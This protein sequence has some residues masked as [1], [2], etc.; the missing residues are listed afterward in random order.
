MKNHSGNLIYNS[1][2]EFGSL[3]VIDIQQR[4]RSLHF[5][6]GTSQSAMFLYNPI[7]LIHKYTQALVMPLCCIKAKR[8]LILGM[9]AGSIAKF[10][11][12]HFKHIILDIVEL[13]AEVI[14][15]A[16]NYF[17][18]PNESASFT[19]H[20]TSAENFIQQ[21][22]HQYDLI[23]ADLFLTTHNNADITVDIKPHL[24]QLANMLSTEGFI[25]INLIGSD[26]KQYSGFDTLHKTLDY[27]LY[28]LDIEKQNTV[29]IAGQQTLEKLNDF[30]FV[31]Q[32]K[33]HQLPWR[34]YVNSLQKI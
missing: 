28:A 34:H 3:E 29:L 30:D 32:E 15:I 14:N 1:K 8:V 6:N 16:Q 33:K 7:P 21:A 13:R 27:H 4:I 10:L 31:C 9:G 26:Y 2:D 24:P 23:I 18:L 19:I 11:H 25:S 5:G 20:H 22:T 17:S 12:Y